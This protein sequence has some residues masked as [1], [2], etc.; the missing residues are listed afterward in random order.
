MLSAGNEDQ[1][2]WFETQLQQKKDNGSLPL[3]VDFKVFVDP[4]EAR[5]GDGGALMNILCQLV[6]MAT[7]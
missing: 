2:A 4:G 3:R 6:R 7:F 1:K 5:A